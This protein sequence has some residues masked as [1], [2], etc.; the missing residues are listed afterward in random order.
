MCLEGGK[1]RGVK[2]RPSA[3]RGGDHLSFLIDGESGPARVPGERLLKHGEVAGQEKSTGQRKGLLRETFLPVRRI[4][5][6]PG[7]KSVWGKEEAAGGVWKKK[8][9]E[10]RANPLGVWFWGRVRRD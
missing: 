8:T 1:G 7:K 3:L 10:P 5:G 2:K 9:K 6:T 4:P